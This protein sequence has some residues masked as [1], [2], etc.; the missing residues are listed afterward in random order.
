VSKALN[1]NKTTDIEFQIIIDEMNNY[2]T[3][4]LGPHKVTLKN[5]TKALELRFAKSLK[6]T[7]MAEG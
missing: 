5:S 3:L 6:K 7:L 4:L 1:D 2:Q